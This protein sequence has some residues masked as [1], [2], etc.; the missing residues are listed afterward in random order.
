MRRQDDPGVVL[1]RIADRPHRRLDTRGVA[2]DAVL[3]RD[4]E[5]DANED[6]LAAEIEVVEQSHRSRQPAHNLL[7]ISVATSTIR[8]ENPHSLSYHDNT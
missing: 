2:D 5:V 7:P 1:H 6:A 4:V 8:F 3:Q